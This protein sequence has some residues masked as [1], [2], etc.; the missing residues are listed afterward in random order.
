MT[1]V[2][3]SCN[4][5]VVGFQE[6]SQC[7]SS[8]WIMNQV[9]TPW[10]FLSSAIK[11]PIDEFCQGTAL[12]ADFMTATRLSLNGVLRQAK[13]SLRIKRSAT[14]S[15]RASPINQ[16]FSQPPLLVFPH[17]VCSA[18]PLLAKKEKQRELLPHA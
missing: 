5:E 6:D 10:A 4:K 9:L 2:S 11:M 13:V 15:L 12:K 16:I 8:E 17:F 18:E 14:W 1:F 7:D 3:I